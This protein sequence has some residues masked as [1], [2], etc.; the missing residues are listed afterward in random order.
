MAQQILWTKDLTA[1]QVKRAYSLSRTIER[2]RKAGNDPQ[3]AYP[4]VIELAHIVIE[5]R[6]GPQHPHAEDMAQDIAVFVL[7]EPGLYHRGYHPWRHEMN[8]ILRRGIDRY[9]NRPG[10][11]EAVLTN[12]PD[13]TL[14]DLNS[15]QGPRITPARMRKLL[16]S[17]ELWLHLVCPEAYPEWV[18]RH[19]KRMHDHYTTTVP[20]SHAL[21]RGYKTLLTQMRNV[22]RHEYV[23]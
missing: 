17:G 21:V 1:R 5:S 23:H 11:V 16:S 4:A 20:M 6:L 22:T 8:I 18:N 3:K 7:L 14:G 10:T 19:L 9:I 12:F 13:V 15:T 2:H